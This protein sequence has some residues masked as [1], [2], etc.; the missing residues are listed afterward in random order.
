[1][2]AVKFF[3]DAIGTALF[4]ITGLLLTF[5]PKRCQSWS[6]DIARNNERLRRKY[7]QLYGTPDYIV[8]AR[9]VG[10]ACLTAAIF[11]STPILISSYEAL[12]LRIR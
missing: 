7:E 8:F 1:M 11:I 9:I 6:I 10:A 5:F 2:E 4:A 12:G 3:A